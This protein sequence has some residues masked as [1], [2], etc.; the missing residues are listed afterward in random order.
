[1][2]QSD[3]NYEV[4][5][6]CRGTPKADCF[7]IQPMLLNLHPSKPPLFFSAG[8]CVVEGELLPSSQPT[9]ATP[10]QRR[11]ARSLLPPGAS[12]PDLKWNDVAGEPCVCVTT[13]YIRPTNNSELTVHAPTADL[14]ALHSNLQ[15]CSLTWEDRP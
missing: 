11:R 14:C 2:T 6:T 15:S 9:K 8:K 5:L 13:A 1:M 7:F 12:L 3:Y 10:N 4:H